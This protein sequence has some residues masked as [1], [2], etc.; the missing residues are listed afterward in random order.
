MTVSNISLPWLSATTPDAPPA[1]WALWGAVAVCYLLLFF[2]PPCLL[3]RGYEK[4]GGITR[5][6]LFVL[7]ML[8]HVGG[9]YALLMA[10]ISLSWVLAALLLSAVVGISLGNLQ[11]VLF[12]RSPRDTDTGTPTEEEDTAEA[13]A[14]APD[15]GG[16]ADSD[17]A[18]CFCGDTSDG[19]DGAASGDFGEDLRAAV[20]ADAEDADTGSCDAA[21]GDP[22]DSS[23]RCDGADDT[24]KGGQN[25]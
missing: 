15:G 20:P 25:R 3:S 10:E 16:T 11:G 22:D 17:D 4:A 18:S 1:V 8:C 13:E 24:G 5:I 6:L 7:L 23:V 9:I 14:N 2:V 21:S 19:Y 12:P